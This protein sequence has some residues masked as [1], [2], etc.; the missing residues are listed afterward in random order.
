MSVLL[1]PIITVL[2]CFPGAILNLGNKGEEKNT[3]SRCK[4]ERKARS[5]P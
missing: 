2:T 5:M 4:V 3:Y 1:S